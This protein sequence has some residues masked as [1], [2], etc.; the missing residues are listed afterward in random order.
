M[1]P[2]DKDKLKPGSLP[3]ELQR[4]MTYVTC[5]KHNIKYPRGSI[6]PACAAERKK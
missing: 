5:N 3:D 6:C 1:I 4:T 2:S